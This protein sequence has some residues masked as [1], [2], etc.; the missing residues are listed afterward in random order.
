MLIVEYIAWALLLIT[1]TELRILCLPASSS[2]GE[3]AAWKFTVSGIDASCEFTS[4]KEIQTCW[5]DTK[6]SV[7]FSE[8][9]YSQLYMVCSHKQMH[10]RWSFNLLSGS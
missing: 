10:V 7:R 5:D 1:K 2:Q 3:G 6:V 8:I 4:T 9:T